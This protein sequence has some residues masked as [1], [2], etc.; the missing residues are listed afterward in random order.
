MA[1]RARIRNKTVEETYKECKKTIPYEIRNN[2]IE[3]RIEGRFKYFDQVDDL[4]SSGSEVELIRR[5]LAKVNAALKLKCGRVEKEKVMSYMSDNAGNKTFTRAGDTSPINS[6]I[7]AVTSVYYQQQAI[8]PFI[9]GH[10]GMK[11]S[12]ANISQISG[13]YDIEN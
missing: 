6:E 2:W 13:S 8:N 9:L 7:S 11:R 10:N 3:S 12:A 5:K 4:K 1:R